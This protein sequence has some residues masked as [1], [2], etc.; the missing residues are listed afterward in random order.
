MDET[1]WPSRAKKKKEGNKVS[2]DDTERGT[3]E[4]MDRRC[5]TDEATALEE[6][7]HYA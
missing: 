3:S 4:G 7:F 5:D 6:N 1:Y 2:L